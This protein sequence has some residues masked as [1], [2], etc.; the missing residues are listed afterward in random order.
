MGYT[1]PALPSM[2]EDAHFSITEDDESWIGSVMP[3]SA[4][5]GSLLAGPLLDTF[6]RRR[7]F[8]FLAI[9]FMI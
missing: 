8:M 2:K 9:P 4:L 3:A 5:I 1:S 6:G 7:T